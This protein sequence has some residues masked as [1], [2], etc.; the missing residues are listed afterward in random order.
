MNERERE[1][2]RW[3]GEERR[4]EGD[5]EICK[6]NRQTADG[7]IS[8]VVKRRHQQGELFKETAHHSPAPQHRPQTSSQ[9]HGNYVLVTYKTLNLCVCVSVCVCVCVCV[10]LCYV[11]QDT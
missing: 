10:C 1:R 3:R 6:S 11:K 9:T 5:E 4:G 8:R 7:S 2:E